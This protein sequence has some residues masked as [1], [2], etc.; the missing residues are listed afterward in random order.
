MNVNIQVE[1]GYRTRDMGVE[2]K[3]QSV[4]HCILEMVP[5]GLV[6][7]SPRLRGFWIVRRHER[8]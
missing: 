3:G 5:I 7:P 2:T 8:E 4:S 1:M 6:P